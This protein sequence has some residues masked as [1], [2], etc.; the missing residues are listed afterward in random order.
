MSASWDS[1]LERPPSAIFLRMICSAHLSFPLSWRAF[2]LLPKINPLSRVRLKRRPYLHSR[3]FL[4]VIGMIILSLTMENNKILTGPAAS[5]HRTQQSLSCMASPRLKVF[6]ADNHFHAVMADK[7][8]NSLQCKQPQASR[9]CDA[10]LWPSLLAS[11]TPSEQC[12]QT[13]SCFFE[14]L[15]KNRAIYNYFTCIIKN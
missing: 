14:L 4:D 6:R 15:N 11:V 12:K 2:V 9:W 3:R 7:K 5:W 1:V 10:T 8:L 13:E